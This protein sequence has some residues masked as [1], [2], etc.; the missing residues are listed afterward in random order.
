VSAQPALQNWNNS[1]T[2]TDNARGLS[3]LS[4][5]IWPTEIWTTDV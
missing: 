5:I 2:V 3:M 4:G 1:T